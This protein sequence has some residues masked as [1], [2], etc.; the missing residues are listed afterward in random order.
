[1]IVINVKGKSKIE[2]KLSDFLSQ[3]FGLISFFI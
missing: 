1:M 2:I 3:N